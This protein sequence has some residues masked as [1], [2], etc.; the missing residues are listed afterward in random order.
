LSVRRTPCRRPAA[1]SEVPA[2]MAAGTRSRHSGTSCRTAGRTGLRSTCQRPSGKRRR[3]ASATRRARRLF[4]TPA[5]PTTV[6]SRAA[7]SSRTPAIT[8]S[9]RPRKL[10]ISAARLPARRSAM[11]NLLGTRPARARAVG[12][13]DRRPPAVADSST[14][15][16][17]AHRNAGPSQRGR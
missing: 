16:P 11:I 15:G 5:G 12:P 1:S 4:P 9:A 8:S 14:T 13:P 17:A 2:P 7:S 6:T 10:V 3:E